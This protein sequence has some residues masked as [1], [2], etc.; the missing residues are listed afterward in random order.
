[1]FYAF[2]INPLINFGIQ[3]RGTKQTRQ[4]YDYRKYENA[5]MHRVLEWHLVFKVVVL[6]CGSGEDACGKGARNN[7]NDRN[8]NISRH[9]IHIIPPVFV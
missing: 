2:F 9:N 5:P 4:N 7:R 3:L 1:M 6:R 8:Q